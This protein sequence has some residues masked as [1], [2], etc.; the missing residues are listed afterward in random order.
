VTSNHIHLLVEGGE[1]RY[2]ISNAMRY[3]S[4]CSAQKYNNR[5]NRPGACWED[6]YH[7][8]AVST[9]AHLSKCMVYI[10]MNMVRAGVVKNPKEWIHSGYHEIIKPKSRFSIINQGAL[11]RLL[12]LDSLNELPLVYQ[13]LVDNEI[14]R[15]DIRKEEM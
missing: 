1:D 12:N 2:A 4:G 5:K 3:L 15:N 6:R 9:D 13:E 14:I 11:L 10:D 7:A 8:T